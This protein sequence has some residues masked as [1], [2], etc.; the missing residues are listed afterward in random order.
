MRRLTGTVLVLFLS[1]AFGILREF[2]IALAFGF[3]RLTDLFYQLAWPLT[4]IV[5][6]S[7]GP[8][9]TAFAARLAQVPPDQKLASIRHYLRRT[10]ALALAV[11]G[12]FLAAALVLARL[13]QPDLALGLAI[14][15]AA[16]AALVCIGFFYAAATALGWTTISAVLLFIGNAGFVLGI[17]LVWL[18]GLPLHA[19]TLPLVQAL[20]LALSLPVCTVIWT[21]MRRHL[22]GTDAATMPLPGLTRA[23]LL[24]GLETSGFLLTQAFIVVL[25]TATGEGWVS[26]TSLAQRVVFSVN[27]LV[28]SP[29]ASLQMLRVIQ[30]RRTDPQRGYRTFMR[31]MTLAGCGLVATLLLLGLLVPAFGPALIAMALPGKSQSLAHVFA[32]MPAFAVWLLPM[33]LNVILCRTMFALSMGEAFT[34]ATVAGYLAANAVRGLVFLAYGLA[35]AIACGAAVE[36]AVTLGLTAFCA[37]RLGRTGRNA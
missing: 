17:C 18:A 33:G 32:L 2:T 30:D 20:A 29:Y 11:A 21:R 27:G 36:L 4:A 28:I 14:S 10:M 9:A 3:S 15:A 31:G 1:R 37:A 5:T 34:A 19:W 35:P 22:P 7:N 26:A 23:F 6:V 24:A 13:G 8:F 25:A 16:A 12:L